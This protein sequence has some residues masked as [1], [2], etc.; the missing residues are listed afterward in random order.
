MR[1]RPIASLR[2]SLMERQPIQFGNQVSRR[3]VLELP[4]RDAPP[5]IN[6]QRA[7]KIAEGFIRK[8]KVDISSCYLFEAVLVS[9]QESGWRFWWANIGGNDARNRDIRI[10]VTMDGKAQL[11]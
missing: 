9:D 4:R 3:E 11:K 1:L 2:F 5:R 6:L 7:L 10:T 8:L